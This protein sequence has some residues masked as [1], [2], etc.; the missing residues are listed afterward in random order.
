MILTIA[1]FKGGVGKTTTAVHLAAYLN[2]KGSTML[3]DG[4]PNR[5]ATSWG[6]RGELPFRTVDERQGYRYAKDYEH[7]VIDTRARPERRD[8]RELA[9]GCDMLV[10]PTTPDALGLDALMLTVEALENLGAPKFRILLTLVPPPPSHIAEEARATLKANKLPVF[11][12][13]ISRLAA[14]QKAAQNGTLVSE[15][16]DDPRAARGWEEY[17][18]V[19]REIVK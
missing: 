19:G 7:I 13:Q 15:V 3:I 4:D 10:I 6:E 16:R 8:L 1:S 12:N 14:F 11:K 17:W 9:E 2:D 5:S 18:A